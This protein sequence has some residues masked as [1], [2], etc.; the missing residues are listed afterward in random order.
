MNI[1]TNF[2]N[3]WRITDASEAHSSSSPKALASMSLIS[4]VFSMSATPAYLH[5]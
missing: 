4:V 5:T 2:D 1:Y 3:F